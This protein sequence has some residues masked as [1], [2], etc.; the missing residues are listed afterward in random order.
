MGKKNL[1][2]NEV[3]ILDARIQGMQEGIL[4]ENRSI[5]FHHLK[6]VTRDGQAF[7]SRS[8]GRHMDKSSGLRAIK[9]SVRPRMQGH[10][11]LGLSL[12]NS[13]ADVAGGNEV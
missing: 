6:R 8:P 10:N 5:E 11:T 12:E 1:S 2:T 3:D 13:S 4:E 7:Q 9:Q